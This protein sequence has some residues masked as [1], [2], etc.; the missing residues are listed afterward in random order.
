MAHSVPPGKKK[1]LRRLQEGSWEV[2]L[3]FTA[4]TSV[5]LF[6]ITKDWHQSVI[7]PVF[8]ELPAILESEITYSLIAVSVLVL[9]VFVG[10][11]LKTIGLWMVL[12]VIVRVYG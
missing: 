5:I 3:L 11:A 12:Y 10:I 2:E 9:L 4:F 8:S 7:I 6:Q 1:W